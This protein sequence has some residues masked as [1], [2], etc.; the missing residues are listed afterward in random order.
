MTN[1]HSPSSA[2]SERAIEIARLID[3]LRSDEGDSVTILCDNPDFN[4][5]PN[6]AIECCGDWTGWLHKRFAADTL[7]DALSMAMV[8]RNLPSPRKVIATSNGHHWIERFNLVCCR[9][10]G[11][12]RRADDQNKPCKGVVGVGLRRDLL[13]DHMHD[14]AQSVKVRREDIVAC[15]SALKLETFPDEE[16]DQRLGV[17][18]VGHSRAADKIMALIALAAPPPAAPVEMAT[19]SAP[20]SS[21]PH[22]SGERLP[23]SDAADAGAGAQCSA[24]SEPVAFINNRLADLA[25]ANALYGKDQRLSAP[26]K[27]ARNEREISW[28]KELRSIIKTEPQEAPVTRGPDCAC[29]EQQ[30]RR[31]CTVP[32][33]TMKDAGWALPAPQGAYKS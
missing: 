20:V 24:A 5:Q 11:F 12:V 18:I 7:L 19:K 23:S 6:C 28:L 16:D 2:E 29:C 26:D 13:P 9:D 25:E 31:D 15:L 14:D 4:G 27:I 3:V 33:C 10:C 17:M 22:N 30:P 21:A 32:G 1:S 8:E